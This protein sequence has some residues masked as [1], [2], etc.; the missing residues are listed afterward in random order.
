MSRDPKNLPALTDLLDRGIYEEEK[1]KAKDWADGRIDRYPISPSRFGSCGL[2]VARDIAHYHGLQ[3]YKKPETAIRLAKIFKRGKALEDAVLED[4]AQYT[5]LKLLQRQQRLYLFTLTSGKV[6]VDIEGDID[7]LFTDH[8]GFRLLTDIKTKGAY[9]SPTAW[10]SVAEMFNNIRNAHGVI[11][12]GTEQSNCYVIEDMD[13]FLPSVDRADFLY[14]YILQLNGYAHSDWF[15]RTGVDACSIYYENKNNSNHYELRWAPNEKLYRQVQEKWQGVFNTVF[16]KGPEAVEKDFNL[17][18][19]RCK[20]CEYHELCWGERPAFN[21]RAVEARTIE[22]L[23]EAYT[24][25]A[26]QVH[27]VKSL[28]D[29]EQ[30]ILLLMEN[31]NVDRIKTPDGKIWERKFLKSPKP[32]FEL[33]QSK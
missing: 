24:A 15:R 32:H 9:S 12:H 23:E 28:A 1:E 21:E 29:T 4:F 6:K 10:D 22:G 19:I 2:Q 7:V 27:S 31:N 16:T 5:G 30:K 11:P 14:G 3:S 20:L 17:G 13:A 33:R 8:T 18:S 26:Y 25:Y